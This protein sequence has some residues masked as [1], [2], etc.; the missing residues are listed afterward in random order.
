MS[1]AYHCKLPNRGWVA[2]EEQLVSEIPEPRHGQMK[3]HTQR[4]P[5]RIA[6]GGT[7]LL[8]LCNSTRRPI[9]FVKRSGTVDLA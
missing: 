1:S 7:I 6:S 5:H 9:A 8:E 3:D 4:L 2:D